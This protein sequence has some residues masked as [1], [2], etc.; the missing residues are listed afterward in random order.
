MS[1]LPTLTELKL[2][3]AMKQAI[4]TA[5]ETGRAIVV[6]YVDE[7]GA[8]HLSFRGSTQAYSDTQLAIW[9]RNPQ[10]RILTATKSNPSV[11]LMYGNFD[12]SAR[13]F[14]VFRGRARIDETAETRRRV[15]EQAPEG[16]R[17]LDKERKGVPLIIDLDSVEGFFGGARLQMRR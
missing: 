4:N 9:V 10:G 14:M 11:A 2:S 15:Y 5:L 13:G 16:E 1:T 3:A 6:A 7:S 8:P 12:P 17:N